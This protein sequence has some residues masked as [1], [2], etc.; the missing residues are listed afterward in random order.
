MSPLP[1]FWGRDKGKTHYLDCRNVCFHDFVES[2]ASGPVDRKDLTY[3]KLVLYRIM[4][5]IRNREQS[6]GYRHLT[7]RVQYYPNGGSLPYP[8]EK[9]SP[10]EESFDLDDAYLARGFPQDRRIASDCLT[11][12]FFKENVR[13]DKELSEESSADIL[14]HC[15]IKRNHGHPDAKGNV[16]E[17]IVNPHL[18]PN[19]FVHGINPYL[20]PIMVGTKFLTIRGIYFCQQN[21]HSTRCAHSAVTMALR[22]IEKKIK[23]EDAGNLKD[24]TTVFVAKRTNVV[25]EGLTCGQIIKVLEDCGLFPMVISFGEKEAKG[26]D[27]GD[28][29]SFVHAGVES[30]LPVLLSFVTSDGANRDR[31]VVTVFGHTLNTNSWVAEAGV[32]YGRPP[33]HG[34][35]PS[36]DWC[37][38][39]IF[40]DDNLGMGYC[41]Q[42]NGLTKPSN[43]YYDSL[44]EDEQTGDSQK[45]EEDRRKR[46]QAERDHLKEFDVVGVIVPLWLPGPKTIKG[47]E[48]KTIAYLRNRIERFYSYEDV[49]EDDQYDDV[50]E[51]V[52]DAQSAPFQD[53]VQWMDR[54][55]KQLDLDNKG[56]GLILR[57]RWVERDK[58]IK[59]FV[60]YL[61]A[62]KI[63]LVD[64]VQAHLPEFFWM[65]EYT[66]ADLFTASRRKLGEI[67]WKPDWA[68]VPGLYDGLLAARIPGALTLFTGNAVDQRNTLVTSQWG[69][70]P[71]IPSM[72]Q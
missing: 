38:D 42:A 3:S 63:A 53:E 67:L 48:V 44:P 72:R 21:G 65:T 58:Y 47:A 11:L 7:A 50:Q 45:Q 26:R 68:N 39:W 36:H 70:V 16:W 54:L 59:H 52:Q 31:H 56:S 64:E 4:S 62:D 8:G 57:S 12:T 1:D 9:P 32:Y 33:E 2:L 10:Y 17:A 6:E 27:I 71:M 37:T 18:L 35:R 55:K 34:Y 20:I 5:L 43:D 28:Y 19:H 29:R 30:G 41:L 23:P 61:P 49:L 25:G 69:H 51:G 14:A 60:G 15:I 40:S 13:D 22:A 24:P 66:L 46:E